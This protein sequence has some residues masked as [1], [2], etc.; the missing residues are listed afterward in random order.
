VSVAQDI[1]ITIPT[2]HRGQVDIWKNR[3]RRN[4][5]RCG[6]R[7][8][9][10]KM[11]V[12]LATDGAAKGL[13]VG[14]FAPEHKQLQ[15]P[16]DEILYTLGGA[17]TGSNK[18]DGVIKTVTGGKVDFWRLIDNELAGRGR[19]YDIILID[20][21]AY[22]KDTQMLD[23][24]RKSIVPTMATKLN[25]SVWAFSTPKGTDTENFFWRL[26]NDP[27]MGFKEFHAPSWANPLVSRDWITEEESRLHPDV[28]RQEILAEW[29]DWSGIAFFSKDKW[30][31]NGLPVPWPAHCDRVFAVIDS[32][33][34]DGTEHDGTAVTYFARNQYAGTPLVILDWDII[35]VESDLLTGWLPGVVFP[36]LEELSRAVGAREGVRGTWV[37]DKASG[38]TLLQHARRRN[39][40]VHA[41]DSE[42]TAIGK[43]ERALAVSS[44]HH[45]GLCKVSEHAHNKTTVYKGI[46]RN[47][48]EAQV[49]GFRLGDRDA[50]KR[51]DDLFDTYVYGLALAL[52]GNKG[53]S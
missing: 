30:L 18:S 36:R 47:H 45:Q 49:V 21:A 46:S 26:G 41:I 20:E 14:V 11:I 29:V 7:F 31:V 25:A 9:K 37:E 10:T 16:Y 15:E 42:F 22:T 38:S 1:R 13:K 17:V 27:D 40:N 4:S 53:F 6:R 33:V 52:G 43:D 32:A 34:K 39:W 3:A 12:T 24:W 5:I 35:Q 23:I 48:L 19:E 44:H 50:A 51:A 28:W 2:F 8:G